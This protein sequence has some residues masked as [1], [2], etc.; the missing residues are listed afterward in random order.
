MS[1]KCD[2]KEI[3]NLTNNIDDTYRY[4][5]K[6]DKCVLDYKAD[7]NF[8]G[9][10]GPTQY[11]SVSDNSNFRYVSIEPGKK[12]TVSFMTKTDNGID[13]STSL[14]VS[15]KEYSTDTI[16]H[17]DKSYVE[18]IMD[19]SDIQTKYNVPVFY[20]EVGI[21]RNVY[22]TERNIDEMSYDI[23]EWLKDNSCNFTWF[24]WHEPNYGL[25]TASGLDI[26]SNPN[27]E[28]LNQIDELYGNN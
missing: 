3:Y 26:K 19:C 9:I 4:W 25:Y 28:L 20:G 14:K 6:S 27:E 11:V 15:V 21:P 7:N 22:Q 10:S 16:Y 1:I 13:K 23:L 12:Y 24:T 5:S 8:I 18:H 2:G 17:L